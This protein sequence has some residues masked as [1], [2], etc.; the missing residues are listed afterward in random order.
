[1]RVHLVVVDPQQ[2]FCN[3]NGSLFVPG[4]DKDMDRLALM[5]K[6]LGEKIDGI[7]VTLDSHHP[8]DISHPKWW[9]RVG[10]GAMPAPFTALGIHPDG[11]RVVRVAF[12]TGIPVFTDEEYTTYL[13]SFLNKN[14]PV[15]TGSMGY[16]RSLATA[17]RYIHVIWPEHCLIGSWGHSV[18]NE[19][20]AAICNWER[21]QFTQVDYVTKG[22]NPWTEH[23]SGVQAEVPDPADLDSQVNTRL[24]QTLEQADIVAIAGEALSHCVGS[25]VTDIIHHVSDPCYVEKLVLL[26]DASSNVAGFD[27]L[28]DAFI[29]DMTAK[30]MNFSTTVDFLR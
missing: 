18:V 10:D 29:K 26:T 5:V 4:A 17:N 2:D 13:P 21:Q 30:G 23:F 6:R 1:M 25:T 19:L 15:N 11:Q 27:F 8:I 22:S 7:H 24:I 20:H 3:P 12:S 9:K 14:G 28:G 16:L